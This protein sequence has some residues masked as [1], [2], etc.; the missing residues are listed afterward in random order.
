MST[1]TESGSGHEAK[2]TLLDFNLE[3]IAGYLSDNKDENARLSVCDLE[4]KSYPL[5][6]N[7]R[8]EPCFVDGNSINLLSQ[9]RGRFKLNGESENRFNAYLEQKR[10]EKFKPV[11]RDAAL[12]LQIDFLIAGIMS[13]LHE[14]A[15]KERKVRQI[16]LKDLMRDLKRKGAIINVERKNNDVLRLVASFTSSILSYQVMSELKDTLNVKSW[17]DPVNIYKVI[18]EDKFSIAEVWDAQREFKF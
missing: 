18:I 7:F 11:G 2:E 9:R 5:T 6:L 10:R 1:K 8:K 12:N 15:M 3:V 17:R 16:L 13:S 14:A 4:G